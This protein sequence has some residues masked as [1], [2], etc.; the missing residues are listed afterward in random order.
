MTNN[1]SAPVVYPTYGVHNTPRYGPC[2]SPDCLCACGPG[3][4]SDPLYP[5]Y[6]TAKW[7]MYRVFNN[8][9]DNPPPYDGKP[10]SSLKEGVD[11]QVSY[12][13][14][15]YDSTWRGPNG[16]EGAMMEYYDE[17]SL[18]IFPIDN[19]YSS[20]FISLGDKAYFLTYDKV[21]PKGMPPICLFSG[22][23]HPP[24]RDFLRLSRHTAR[25]AHSQSEFRRVR[26][27]PAGP[28]GN[29]GPGCEVLGRQGDPAGLQPVWIARNP[30]H[31]HSQETHLGRQEIG[32]PGLAC[33]L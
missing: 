17:W 2:E 31:S 8:Y 11:Y 14:S 29:L 20:A 30:S 3:E 13:V 22:I 1:D 33:W 4:P 10:P 26:Y 15:Y 25:C 32:G 28:R 23:N 19:H 21:R 6:W 24:R 18:S 7:T 27:D 9:V 5:L 12:G 16:E